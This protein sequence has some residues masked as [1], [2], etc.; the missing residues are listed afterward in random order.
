[1]SGTQHTLRSS[2]FGVTKV[3]DKASTQIVQATVR[4][5]PIREIRLAFCRSG[6]EKV[7]YLEYV[8]RNCAI[9]KFSLQTAGESGA[10]LPTENVQ[11]RFASVEITYFQQS[12]DSGGSAGQISTMWNVSEWRSEE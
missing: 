7:K 3:V 1:M 9:T 12:R 6:Q 10:S 4:N 2:Q 8:F 5:E 11:F